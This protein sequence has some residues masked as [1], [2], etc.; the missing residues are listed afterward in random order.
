MLHGTN[1]NDDFYRDKV[2]QYWN[3]AVSIGSN[4]ATIVRTKISWKDR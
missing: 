2:L 1:R 3:N 4:I